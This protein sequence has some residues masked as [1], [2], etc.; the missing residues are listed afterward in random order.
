MLAHK[1]DA[2]I[3]NIMRAVRS[4]N[5]TP[6]VAQS[7]LLS[8]QQRSLQLP[9]QDAAL[10]DEFQFRAVQLQLEFDDP[11]AEQHALLLL[12]AKPG[13]A[14]VPNL[15]YWL[16]QAMMRERRR[17]SARGELLQAIA[18]PYSTALLDHQ[19]LN[20]GIGMLVQEPD[21]AVTVQWLLAAAAKL[22]ASEDVARALDAAASR[23]SIALLAQLRQPHTL[24][25]GLL[26]GIYQR[27]AWLAVMRGQHEVL[28]RVAGWATMDLP[29]SDAAQLIRQWRRGGGR[30]AV[31]GVLLPLSGK[32]AKFGMQALHGIRLAVSKLA[33]GDQLQLVIADSASR[34]EGV[35]AAYQRLIDAGSDIVIGPLLA[36][37]VRTLAPH[38]HRDIPLFA[39]TNQRN[40]AGLSPALFIHSAGLQFQAVFLADH[41]L[42]QQAL[43]FASNGGDAPYSPVAMKVAILAAANAPSQAAAASFRQVLRQHGVKDVYQ[44]MID[45]R[46][47]E[48]RALMG[49]RRE[50]DDG[51]LLDTLDEEM[52]LFIADDELSPQMPP[53]L[54]AIYLPLS[55]TQVSRLAG[56]LAYVGLNQVPLLGD[57][58]WLDGHLLDDHG[59][60]LARSQI[61][62]LILGSSDGDRERLTHATDADYRQLWGDAHQ[63][64]LGAI[65]FDSLLMGGALVSSWG[66]H[67]QSLIDALHTSAGFPL[68]SGAVVFDQQG[69]GHKQFSLQTV[70]HGA[71]V[72]LHAG[73]A[74]Q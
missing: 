55:G 65:A 43:A 38:L 48:R 33:Y 59:R 42:R 21:D 62:T 57:G 68:A 12:K 15:H 66:L 34:S 49:L 8:L 52:A 60:Y 18:D 24:G 25:A 28:D 56:Q 46:V 27:V 31:I 41:V 63:S 9:Q 19:A 51:M 3:S 1:S 17:V 22:K 20:M 61:A 6:D 44:L 32:Y 7:M 36:N 13:Y 35:L 39:L 26:A 37:T 67:G 50:S 4:G 54:D 70:R 69:V 64:P 73:A 23:T 16:A 14:L 72:V 45:G 58:G 29:D 40:L 5:I 53:G 47:D 2:Q 71:L 10:A 30:P 11:Y 74:S